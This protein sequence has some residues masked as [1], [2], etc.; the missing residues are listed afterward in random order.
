M[1]RKISSD[2]KRAIS[3]QLMART[4]LERLDSL[5]KLKYPSNTLNDYY[6]ILHNL[7]ESLAS[8]N[9]IKFS[10]N[11]AHKELIDWVCKELNYSDQRH[12][13]LQQIRNYRNKIS[14]EG[15]FVKENFIKQNNQKIMDIIHE[16]IK[17]LWI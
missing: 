13:F 8:L 15:F 12:I 4:T 11:S 1:K 9:G 17:E 16:L 10:G 14:Y 2:K 7:M 6:D 3:L 5:D